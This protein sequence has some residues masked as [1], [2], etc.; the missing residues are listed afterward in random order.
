MPRDKNPNA[1]LGEPYKIL[2]PKENAHDSA[3]MDAVAYVLVEDGDCTY[4]D[5]HMT[6]LGR[7][8]VEV[9]ERPTAK[10]AIA[11]ARINDAEL[12][13][14]SD[15]GMVIWTEGNSHDDWEAPRFDVVLADRTATFDRLRDAAE[16]ADRH[17]GAT[18]RN[19]ATEEII[20]V[21]QDGR[22]YMDIRLQAV[23]IGIRL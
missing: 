14:F 19:D 20:H 8:P 3:L 11:F 9:I 17:P 12:V 1:T 18:I 4:F 13:C 23:H 5:G 15:L 21:I 7:R 2:I 6:E 10:Q 16:F 22:P